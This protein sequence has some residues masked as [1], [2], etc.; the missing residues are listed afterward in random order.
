MPYW[1]GLLS[2]HHLRRHVVECILQEHSAVAVVELK[3][4]VNYRDIMNMTRSW[5]SWEGLFSLGY[6]YRQ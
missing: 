4:P 3:L 5:A 2:C 1:V 6:W